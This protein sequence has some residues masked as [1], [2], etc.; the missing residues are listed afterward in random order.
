MLGCLI[1]VVIGMVIGGVVMTLVWR[2]NRDTEAKVDAGI[3][4]AA[5]QIL[6]TTTNSKVLTNT[7]ASPEQPTKIDPQISQTGADSKILTA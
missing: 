1:A 5:K 3:N 4:Q 7:S 2:R 6:A